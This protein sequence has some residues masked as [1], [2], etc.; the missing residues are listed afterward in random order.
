M[1]KK[2]LFL[3]GI[4]VALGVVYLIFFTEM[5]RTPGIQIE[6]TSRQQPNRQRLGNPRLQAIFDA[7]APVTF[8]F[9]RELRLT[10]VKVF[11]V[12]EL[13]TNKY[14]LPLWH[15]VSESNSVSLKFFTYGL[16]IRGMHPAN[17]GQDPKPLVPGADYRVF[18][19]A[20]ERKGQ[21]DFKP[22]PNPS[23]RA[24]AQP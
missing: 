10:Q 7:T 15:M 3:I 2:N 8:F 21:R 4:T 20:G 16:P 22:N 1:T 5:F 12:P 9:P 11:S 24:P 23:S 19:E 18:I 14:P 17:K 6:Y 13:E